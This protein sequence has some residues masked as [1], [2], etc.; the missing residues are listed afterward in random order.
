M[1]GGDSRISGGNANIPITVGEVSGWKAYGDTTQIKELTC[2]WGQLK[3]LAGEIE[4]L[5]IVTHEL[6]TQERPLD[7]VLVLYVG[8]APCDHFE[9][10]WKMFPEF[11][12]LLW[13]PRGFSRFAHEHA[14][15]LDKKL[16]I[17]SGEPKGYFNDDACAEVRR[18]MGTIGC[19]TLVYIN[20]MRRVPYE[21]EIAEDMLNQQK[22]G[23][24]MG[25]D[26]MY[27][28]FRLPYLIAQKEGDQQ[29]MDKFVTMEKV[30]LRYEEAATELI[31]SGVADHRED[32]P[33]Y[34]GDD[35]KERLVPYLAGEVYLQCFARVR[36]SEMRILVRKGANGYAVGMYNLTLM[37]GR[38][39]HFNVEMRPQSLT[40]DGHGGSILELCERLS[41]LLLG[42]TNRYDYLRFCVIVRD[43]F[44][45]LNLQ[46]NYESI[47]DLLLSI[48]NSTLEERYNSGSTKNSFFQCAP[49]SSVSFPLLLRSLASIRNV[50]DRWRANRDYHM[51]KDMLQRKFTN[52][53]KLQYV[54]P[55]GHNRDEL[56]MRGVI[57]PQRDERTIYLNFNEIMLRD[58]WIRMA[59]DALFILSHENADGRNQN[60]K[61]KKKRITSGR[62][63]FNVSV[64]K[65]LSSPHVLP[66]DK[67][68]DKVVWDLITSHRIPPPFRATDPLGSRGSFQYAGLVSRAVSHIQA[69]QIGKDDELIDEIGNFYF[70]DLVLAGLT[71]GRIWDENLLGNVVGYADSIGSKAVDPSLIHRY[72]K[73]RIEQR[74][75]IFTA[76]PVANALLDVMNVMRSTAGGALV[77]PM[78]MGEYAVAVALYNKAMG[79]SISLEL[80][81]DDKGRVSWDRLTSF[82]GAEQEYSRDMDGKYVPLL[83]L[84]FNNISLRQ[85]VS[86]APQPALAP[87]SASAPTSRG[88]P[89]QYK[90]GG[91]ELIL[92]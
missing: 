12:W 49:S 9:A 5:T 29:T 3:L 14:G 32:R 21:D 19:D 59:P 70:W 45:V 65:E 55:F 74:S 58:K 89:R 30:F 53:Y 2:H 51:T 57:T 28:K 92:Y 48:V 88:Q 54:Y 62:L 87:A 46:E 15:L 4:L 41:G 85:G 22:W 79:S 7:H 16:R 90:R 86:R 20:D 6:R 10:I 33:P 78:G 35:M 64:Y 77:R 69:R 43:A 24:K 23:V 72:T 47:E 31:S 13:D 11:K 17:V 76:P 38:Y 82:Q 52:I 80:E 73:Q 18:Y 1:G 68:V 71:E 27:M 26:Y 66:P 8:A 60:D 42:F 83:D 56:V 25:A 61:N 75:G 39:N 50:F 37:D 40:D 44:T 36:S 81:A 34:P 67:T 63:Y 91:D 84:S